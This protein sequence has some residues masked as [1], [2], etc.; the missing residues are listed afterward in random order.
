LKNGPGK[1]CKGRGLTNIVR[2]AQTIGAT[3]A[4]EA[5]EEGGM[6]TLRLPLEPPPDMPSGRLAV[7][8]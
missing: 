4:W 7:G 6:F 3:C 5:T 1:S 2:R 8:E